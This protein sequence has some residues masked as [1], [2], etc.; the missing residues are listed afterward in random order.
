MSYATTGI[1]PTPSRATIRTTTIT[2]RCGKASRISRRSSIFYALSPGIYE[3]LFPCYLTAWTHETLTSTVAVGS[4][5]DLAALRDPA[6]PRSLDRRYSTVEAKVRL[7]QAE[8][9]E[10]VLDAYERRCAVSG[11]PL[12]AL[13]EAAHI[14][15]DRDER[16][17]PDIRNGICLSTLHHAAY[18]R[19]LLG[20]DPDG[21]IHISEAVLG[22]HDGP[23]LE[24]ALKEFHGARM[25]FPRHRADWPLRDLLAERFERVRSRG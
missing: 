16:G 4:P 11:L 3:I 21:G 10:L 17:R 22:Q 23:T 2:Q 15:P 12:P 24:K 8:F 9:R 25:R 1:F 7:D 13:L 18:D 6:L 20:I 14:I 5:L 19:D